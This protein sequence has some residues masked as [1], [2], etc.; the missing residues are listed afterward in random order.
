MY[1]KIIIILALLTFLTAC[2]GGQSQQGGSGNPDGLHINF[3]ESQPRQELREKESFDIGLKL[4]NRAECDIQGDIC[5]RDTLAQSISGVQDSC[6]EFELRKKDGNN[7]DS[8]NI[9][10]TDN[11]YESL[12]GDLN[13]NIIAKAQYSCSIQLTPQVCVK[14]NIEDEDIC[15][16]KET[17]T[18]ST[19]GL[20]QAP[21]T[22][23][24]INKI[25]IP[26]RDSI[27][28]ETAIHLRKMS[29]GKS[30]NFNI[31]L[32]YEGYGE[33]TCRNLDRLNFE[34]GTENII[35]CEIPINV[36]DIEQNPLKIKLDYIYEITK[37]KQ[38][39]I[40]KEG[41]L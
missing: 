27:K 14:P 4:E 39:K 3:L 10:F 11:I 26:Q 24:S 36:V 37:S 25:L 40:T 31:Y 35:N 12:S 8:Q 18:A 19:L 38:I 6:Q 33:L 13:S 7:I 30:N 5:I 34:R 17:L 9:Y 22:V 32:E 1:K 41:D 15:K 20:K 28:L 23:S 29:E 2:S 16:T 21:I